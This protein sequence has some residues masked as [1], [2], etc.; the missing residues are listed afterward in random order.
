[1]KNLNVTKNIKTN[2]ERLFNIPFSY[3]HPTPG[4]E[5]FQ[6]T[7]AGTYNTHTRAHTKRKD[8]FTLNSDIL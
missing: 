3:H 1:M 4:K 5:K 2:V 6:N 7:N 8:Y